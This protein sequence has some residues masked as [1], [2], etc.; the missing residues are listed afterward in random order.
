VHGAITP[1]PSVKCALAGALESFCSGAIDETQNALDLADRIEWLTHEEV[2]D[3]LV[4][5]DRSTRP[6][7]NR[8]R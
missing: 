8:L 6:S 4:A 2:T 3:Q 7:V 5:L 1:V